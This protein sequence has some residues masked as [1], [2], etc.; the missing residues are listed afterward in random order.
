M[1][2]TLAST[3]ILLGCMGATSAQPPPAPIDKAAPLKLERLLIHAETRPLFVIVRPTWSDE[4]IGRWVFWSGNSSAAR[5]ELESQLTTQ[6][7]D[8]DR[9]C[10][11]TDREK[12]KLQLAGRG[13]IKRFFDR[14]QQES[15]SPRISL[16]VCLFHEDSLLVKSLPNTLTAEQ[17]ARYEA[18][19]GKRRELRHRE[20]VLNAVAMLKLGFERAVAALNR[21]IVLREEQRQELITLTMHETRPLRRPG[22][23]DYQVLILQL[24]RLQEEKLK[25][26]FDQDQWEIMKGIVAGY[27]RQEPMLRQE[28]LLPIEGDAGDSTAK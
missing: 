14:I 26:L 22:P 12:G 6:I 8:I 24:G 23:S 28:G 17:F 15:T 25:R 11:L 13:D 9:A 18:I 27:Q 16:G 4:Q 2:R 5:Q 10:S 1:S 3:L 7:V 19:A 20:S 21:D